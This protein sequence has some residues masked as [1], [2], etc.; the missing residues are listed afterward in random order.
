MTQMPASLLPHTSLPVSHGTF[1]IFPGAV[2]APLSFKVSPVPGERDNGRE[3]R[4]ACVYLGANTGAG[5]G[6]SAPVGKG[7]R[8]TGK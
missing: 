6:A 2:F 8:V 4:K 7:A 3:G 1:L 5:T